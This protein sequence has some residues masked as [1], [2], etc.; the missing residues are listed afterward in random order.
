MTCAALASGA[1]L[2]G[3]D[4]AALAALFGA[5]LAGLLAIMIVILHTARL[6]ALT[7]IHAAPITALAVFVGWTAFTAQ[8]TPAAGAPDWWASLFHPLWAAFGSSEA[9]VS[10]S[11]YR[12]LEGLAMFAAPVS[13]FGLGALCVEDRRDRDFI[14][15][16]FAGAALAL[17][18]WSIYLLATGGE[19]NNN[20]LM[21]P[22]G[23]SNAAAT[24]FGLFAIFLC[25][26]ILRAARER[27]S[28]TRGRARGNTPAWIAL[29][30]QAPV[31]S[32]ALALT[33]GCAALTG[34]RAGLAA[35]AGGL[36]LFFALTRS[37]ARGGERAGGGGQGVAALVATAAA[38][39][40][41]VGGDFLASRFGTFGVDAE[42]RRLMIETHWNA[43][44]DR[45]LFGH[46]LNTFH[47][48][49]AYYATVENWP[50]LRDIGAAHNIFV[51]L[52]EETGLVGAI[53]FMVML[54]PPLSRLLQIAIEDRSG[55]EWAAASFAGAAFA[56]AHGLVDFGL[57]VPAIAA[58]MA[59][60]LGA[61]SS[62]AFDKRAAHPASPPPTEPSSDPRA[63]M[64]FRKPS[65][66][67]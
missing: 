57:Q 21:A 47:E 49:N 13:A 37:G 32:A 4:T 5:A 24:I 2:G 40:L 16:L 11:P 30:Q 36:A 26:L 19:T 18:F 28:G 67:T 10:I 51:Q 22:F 54:A 12:T 29:I 46:G 17:G 53:L 42:G 63:E 44:A 31:S 65:A 62:S 41:L 8:L 55:A 52:L 27:L 39:F 43:F 60:G 35:L 1:M 45:P 61:F 3:M 6:V 33:L 58:F 38:V 64:R 7:R 48:L 50:A 9:A 34:S 59:F 66:D 25:A 56:F 14:G 20:R 15:R 23:S